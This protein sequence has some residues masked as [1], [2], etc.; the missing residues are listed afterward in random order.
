MTTQSTI[1]KLIEM[2]LDEGD[3]HVGCI[4]DPAARC[5]DE[6]HLF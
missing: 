2:G 5:P 1:D 3:I 4:P 6:G